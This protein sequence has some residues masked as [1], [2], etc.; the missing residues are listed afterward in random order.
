MKNF[1]LRA[2]TLL[3]VSLGL[4]GCFDSSSNNE[5][6]SINAV[7]D[8]FNVIG[9]DTHELDV[10]GND[11]G[12]GLV[13]IGTGSAEFG[14]VEFT[15]GTL[16][17]TPQTDFAGVDTFTYSISNEAGEDS[18][19]VTVE[20]GQ[21][22]ALQ[23]RVID[24]PIADA[25]VT[26]EFNGQTFTAQ[27]DAQGRYHL[28]MVV[29]SLDD[30]ELVRLSARGSAEHGQ[31]YV[32][33]SSRLMTA[34]EL[35][36]MVGS[37]NSVTRDHLDSVQVTQMSTARDFLINRA[38]EEGKVTS[39]NIGDLENVLDPDLMLE[40]AAVIKLMVDNPDFS[41]PEG[42]DTIDDFLN[43]A[44]S[45]NEVVV[46]A[47]EG[48]D[49]SPLRRAMDETL[50]DPE[51]M[52]RSSEQEI[53]GD[54]LVMFDTAPFIVNR[55]GVHFA[56]NEDG[57]A[58]RSHGALDGANAPGRFASREYTW[59]VEGSRI[60]F[61]SGQGD[62]EFETSVYYRPYDYLED[63]ETRELYLT[64]F[65]DKDHEHQ[66]TA[67]QHLKAFHM[68]SV[69]SRDII[70]RQ[71][72]E[73]VIPEYDQRRWDNE[74]G[75]DHHIYI[76]ERTETRIS[77]SRLVKTEHL[78]RDDL[79][80]E[81][82]SAQPWILTDFYGYTAHKNMFNLLENGRV[83]LAIDDHVYH[84]ASFYYLQNEDWQANW[85]LHDDDTRLR[86]TLRDDEDNL[87]THS[88][89]FW[90]RRDET[91]QGLVTIY[92]ND[93]GE[94]YASVDQGGPV[95]TA[96]I[97]PEDILSQL[98][99][100][101]M[102]ASAVNR[103]AMAYEGATLKA[104]DWFGWILRENGSGDRPVFQCDGAYIQSYAVCEGEFVM[105]PFG[106]MPLEWRIDDD[107]IR[108]DRFEWWHD[109][110]YYCT[111][112]NY[113]QGTP[114]FQRVIKPL[115]QSDN[116]I[117]FGMEYNVTNS[118][119]NGNTGGLENGRPFYQVEPRFMV[120]TIED[121]PATSDGSGFG[122]VSSQSQSATERLQP[123]TVDY[124]RAYPS[125]HHDNRDGQN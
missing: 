123:F 111:G 125:R 124:V 36:S 30:N 25:T 50:N 108:I 57:T 11:E 20:V 4:A 93:Y 68:V 106:Q 96:E 70:I 5:D 62:T 63:E 40:M 95:P 16:S 119:A 15:E 72:Y 81:N 69:T 103:P 49:D 10:L 13:I 86:I 64:H 83:E 33:L 19:T 9:N 79:K 32:T 31:E 21:E 61:E 43:D 120:W 82:V 12:N 44:E 66:V 117:I 17:Y 6:P 27:A 65:Y 107:A 60:E 71:E 88:D 94:T 45:Y 14:T 22:I 52:P 109:P 102:L 41:L 105:Q 100:N 37:G 98:N 2:G 42:K 67:S 28:P 113:P 23:G 59:N 74:T 38:S 99:E 115:R 101:N 18:A 51:I 92:S 26:L 24:A 54:Y 55:S 87:I 104:S 116:G 91:A 7:A 3:A 75:V 121:L 114:C 110:T 56:F 122:G 48:G 78:I 35:L 84:W 34:A 77:N 58:V 53:S 118:T 97:T 73:L 8:N 85:A 29:N 47:S 76:P 39:D 112:E 46:K 89:F 1:K 90:Q 80:F